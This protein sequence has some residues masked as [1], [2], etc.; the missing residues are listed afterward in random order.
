MGL[1][2]VWSHLCMVNLKSAFYFKINGPESEEAEWRPYFTLGRHGLCSWS[3]V[4]E[5]LKQRKYSG[6]I[7]L[8]A[9]Y[10]EQERVTALTSEDLKYAKSLL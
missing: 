1:D 4:V 10:D 7:C 5:Y 6:V 9:E 8:T 2:A 3:R